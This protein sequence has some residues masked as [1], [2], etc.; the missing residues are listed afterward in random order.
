MMFLAFPTMQRRLA[1]K[2]CAGFGKRWRQN[3]D[4][5]RPVTNHLGKAQAR[6]CGIVTLPQILASDT[7][8]PMRVLAT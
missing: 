5:T 3:F 4:F 1:V 6:I 2:A 8:T 7:L